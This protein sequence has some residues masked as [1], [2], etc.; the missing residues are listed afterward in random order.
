FFRDFGANLNLVPNSLFFDCDWIRYQKHLDRPIAQRLLQ[1]SRP[2]EPAMKIH[3]ICP[4]LEPHGCKLRSKP[5]CKGIVLGTCVTD[6]QSGPH[7]LRLTS[8][9][10]YE[11]TDT[12]GDRVVPIRWIRP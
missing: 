9:A 4:H 3:H 11:G 7:L 8:T 12:S 10:S 6:E 5:T 2:V 1:L